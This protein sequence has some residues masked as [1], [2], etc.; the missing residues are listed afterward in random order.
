MVV[1]WETGGPQAL[2][3]S[4]PCPGPGRP[5]PPISRAEPAA[6]ISPAPWRTHSH[7]ELAPVPGNEPALVANL[8]QPTL[9]TALQA[10][11]S[12]VS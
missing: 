7:S 12:P 1:L 3:D 9:V 4:Y 2:S 10:E 5:F 11:V 6:T 8:Y